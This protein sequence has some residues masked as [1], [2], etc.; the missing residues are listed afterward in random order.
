MVTRLELLAGMRPKEEVKTRY[1]MSRLRW[2]D[3]DEQVAE[4]A[5]EYGRRWR[6]SHHTIDGAD[7]AVA[8]TAT[9]HGL[10][11]ST[12]NLQHFPMFPGLTRPY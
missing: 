7:L 3:V 1:L 8:A 5:G 11:L 4:Q 9:V 10:R 2:H 12:L 6:P